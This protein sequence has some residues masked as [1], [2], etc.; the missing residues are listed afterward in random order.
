M[1]TQ[2][3]QGVH[4]HTA[5]HTEVLLMVALP[6]WNSLPR[7]VH[8]RASLVFFTPEKDYFKGPL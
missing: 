4:Y 7:V 5:T 6:L 2:T 8:L 1:A 3:P